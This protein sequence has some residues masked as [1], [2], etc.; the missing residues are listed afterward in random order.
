MSHR[1]VAALFFLNVFCGSLSN[2]SALPQTLKT[3][4]YAYEYWDVKDGLPDG[5]VF[6]IHHSADGFL[7][8]GTKL[9]LVRFDGKEFVPVEMT[10][11]SAQQY[12]FVRGIVEDRG[13]ALYGGAIG[14][15]LQ[16][17]ALEATLFGESAGLHHPFVYAI[18][19]APEG[20]MWVGSGGSGVWKFEDNRF[21]IHPA[22]AA[23]DLPAK[24]N[25]LLVHQNGDLWVATDQ[26]IVILGVAV[27]RVGENDGLPAMGVNTL[28]PSPDGSVWAGTK[29]GMLQLRE[30]GSVA[31]VVDVNL[32]GDHV[33]SIWMDLDGQMWCGTD[34]GVLTRFRISKTDVAVV[35]QVVRSSGIRVIAEDR[36]GSIWVGT[37]DRLERYQSGAVVTTSELEGLPEDQ[38]MNVI[39]L[40]GGSLLVLDVRGA[41]Y[42]FVD[43]EIR[44][45]APPG[46]FS[47]E[48]ML[49]MAQSRDGSVYVGGRGLHRL[50]RNTIET[51]D[52]SGG[53]F[54]VLAKGPGDDILT[55]QTGSDGISRLSR[56]HHGRFEPIFMTTSLHHVQRIFV[57]SKSRIW[58][59]S[60]GDGVLRLSADGE[61]LF[62][63]QDGLP[64]NIVY[65]ILEDD[66]QK[67]WVSTR[68]GLAC[69]DG[70]Q[71]TPLVSP[72]PLSLSPVHMV[73]APNG[74][75]V[76]TTDDGVLR[77]TMSQLDG[78]LE[79][80]SAG[81]QYQRYSLANGL[82]GREVSWR[83]NGV[84]ASADNSIWLATN[85]GIA[86]ICSSVPQA[87][88]TAGVVID[89][90]T[91]DGEPRPTAGP[92]H[93]QSGKKQLSF[94]FSAPV[95]QGGGPV[96]Y[97]YR[98]AGYDA[99]WISVND[100][101][102]AYYTNVSY[103]AYRFEVRAMLAGDSTYTTSRPV[104]FEIARARWQ[105]EMARASFFIGLL[106]LAYAGHRLRSRHH[107]KQRKRLEG[108][109]A[110]RTAELAEL[111]EQLEGRVKRRTHELEQTNAALDDEKERLA[112]TLRNLTEGV[113]AVDAAANVMLINDFATRLIQQTRESVL[114]QPVV[115]FISL[116]E[117]FTG[118]SVS[119]PLSDV[120]RED[121]HDSAAVHRAVLASDTKVEILVDCAATAVRDQRGGLIGAVMVI[122]D[123]TAKTRAEEKL[124]QTQKLEAVSVLAGGIA[125]DFN[126][127]I[128]G[129]VGYMDLAQRVIGKEHLASKWLSNSVEIADNARNLTRQ[130]L[131]FS[132]G[133]SPATGSHS[134]RGLVEQSCQF[135]LSG[136]PISL[137]LVIDEALRPCDVDPQQMRQVFDNLI[138]NAR[139]AIEA[140]EGGGTLTIRMNN[141]GVGHDAADGLVASEYVAVELHNTGE[142]ISSDILDKIFDPFFTT[143][144]G[145]TG[146]G[147]AT[148]HSIVQRHG[149]DIA[150]RSGAD[151][152]TTF[153][154][155]LR[156]ANSEPESVEETWEPQR[157]PTGRGSILVV[158]DDPNIRRITKV[159]LENYGYRVL[160]AA[161]GREME[162][163]YRQEISAGH[164]VVMAIV[165]YIIPGNKGGLHLLKM[166]KE[167]DASLPVLASSGYSEKEVLFGAEPYRFD[168]LLPKPYTV[169]MLISAVSRH[170]RT[171]RHS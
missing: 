23:G 133:K 77:T 40:A 92:F 147:L 130:L 129:I 76:I 86:K 153:V 87:K 41:V 69:I 117:R 141:C 15:V 62:T 12:T 18:A 27:R 128:T 36:H 123:V 39:Q 106:L 169:S 58:V 131:S 2:A 132:S 22:Y 146:L 166:L 125:H 89:E 5:G 63:V 120:L 78:T 75:V 21:T 59:S 163:L 95:I 79:G 134:L 100:R 110:E 38:L 37:D 111:N 145:G 148:V 88:L 42:E 96:E 162:A 85:R 143:K 50:T 139:Q 118:Q 6:S 154:V 151:G 26:G 168:G 64:H 30:N 11:P 142:G 52:R 160:A 137:E 72:R 1:T 149:G 112:I 32:T 31:R 7:W 90:V 156:A 127:M 108:V 144:K 48:G 35:D 84:T 102:K 43:G 164:A 121:A 44:P 82:R 104:R 116:R 60:G 67:I 80:R 24:V 66:S 99:D 29:A 46:T 17:N 57:D 70:E 71:V 73:A 45:W 9:G 34:D 14:G 105:T 55:A 159:A 28:Y 113:V 135:V 140:G 155:R 19:Q 25:D 53:E 91:V 3:T 98:L 13:G 8:V 126:N 81:L 122:S 115:Q 157:T 51:F 167:W 47:G 33:S 161:D 150:V 170:V 56:F 54:A 10:E 94:H 65:S 119:L 4:Q 107:R 68:T 109:V 97:A 158:D 83:P 152:G 171:D 165:D 136:S 74:T 93:L 138:L 16:V 114:N 20:V 124:Q 101:Q 49:G 61:R 103:G